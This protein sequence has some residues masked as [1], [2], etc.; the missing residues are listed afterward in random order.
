MASSQRDNAPGGQ[1]FE[2]RMEARRLEQIDAEALKVFRSG[3]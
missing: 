3:W 2:R 1:Q